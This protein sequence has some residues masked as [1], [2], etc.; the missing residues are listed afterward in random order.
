[1]TGVFALVTAISWTFAYVL[2]IRV[3]TSERTFGL[4][5]V[6][7][8]TSFSWEFCFTFVRPVVGIRQWVDV[9]WFAFDCAIGY[10]VLRYGPR[11]F[12]YL[13][14]RVS[15]ACIGLN[16]ASLQ[17]D[18]SGSTITGIGDNIGMSGLFRAGPAARGGGRGQSVGIA[19]PKPVGTACGSLTLLTSG[20]HLDARG[21]TPLL[22]FMYRAC[23]VLDLAY[24]AALILV[25]RPLLDEELAT[26]RRMEK[27]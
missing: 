18:G 23:L 20:Q 3:G 21:R 13:D 26:E 6:A 11:E 4:P 9:V 15:P 25:R 16:G 1:M 14:R 10:T 27:L 22:H 2:I 19:A 7:L 8:A 5:I 17:F 24:L 12:P